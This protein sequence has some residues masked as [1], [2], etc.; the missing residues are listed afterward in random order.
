[1]ADGKV[2]TARTA[3]ALKSLTNYLHD[4]WVEVPAAAEFTRETEVILSASTQHEPWETLRNR[5]FLQ[6]VVRHSRRAT[7]TIRHV[8]SIHIEDD[9]TIGSLNVARIDFD[10]ARRQV[11]IVG[12]VPTSISLTGAMVDVTLS[13]ADE[14]VDR[15]E[16]WTL[17]RTKGG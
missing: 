17:R 3:D 5:G 6:R 11:R 7:L 16:R 4:A 13:I 12:H 14:V 9:A 8:T 2:I 10:A 15:R 1:M